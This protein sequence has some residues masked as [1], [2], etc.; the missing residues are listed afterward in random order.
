M[1]DLPANTIQRA[2][3]VRGGMPRMIT[4][5]LAWVGGCSDSAGWPGMA[6][7][8]PVTHEPCCAYV[9]LGSKKTLMLDPGHYGL[10]YS[11]EGQ[12]DAV[13]QGRQLDY[14]FPSH[15]EIP[16]TGNLGR[17]LAKYPNCVA[18]GNVNDYHLFHPEVDLERLQ[19]KKHGD[20]IDLGDREFVFLDAV[21]KDLSGTMWGYDTKLKLIATADG[22]GFIHL[23]DENNCGTLLHEMSPEELKAVT[24]RAAIPFYGLR[25]RDQNPRVTAFRNLM[26][27]YP[28]EIIASGH[29]GPI[30]GPPLQPTIEKLLAKIAD[31]K[32]GAVFLHSQ[33]LPPHSGLDLTA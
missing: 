26:A 32:E 9:I 24:D 31:P 6:N 28:I 7:K 4:P 29:C 5:D 17:L 21:W 15:Q 3:I 30:M 19:P 14:V 8:K 33:N 23:H 20:R 2:Y 11:L 25:N 10:W 13:L 27:K 18:V 12:L 22:F 16:H 1:S